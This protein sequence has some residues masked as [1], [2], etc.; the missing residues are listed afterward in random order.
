MASA[1][2][3]VTHSFARKFPDVRMRAENGWKHRF[4]R[5]CP[6]R[7]GPEI[8]RIMTIEVFEIGFSSHT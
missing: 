4:C 5:L 1:A 3:K 8:S 7:L 2:T 6:L